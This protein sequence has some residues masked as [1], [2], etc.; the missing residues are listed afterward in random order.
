MTN[1][2]EGNYGP[3]KIRLNTDTGVLTM[4]D[5]QGV[6]FRV[7]L[8]NRLFGAILKT[9]FFWIYLRNAGKT[10]GADYAFNWILGNWQGEIQKVKETFESSKTS[11]WKLKLEGELEK[12]WIKYKEVENSA[13]EDSML[14]QTKLTADRISKMKLYA[15]QI[16][17]LE[18]VTQK[19]LKD[20][21]KQLPSDQIQWL[22]QRMHDE[23]VFAGWG[24]STLTHCNY[25]KGE[26]TVE[27]IGSFIARLYYYWDQQ[28]KT[29]DTNCSFFEGYFLGEAE[30]LFGRE[31]LQ[32]IERKCRLKGDDTCVFE[33]S[34]ERYLKKPD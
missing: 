8:I 12:S 33:I 13:E 3:A 14:V 32:C 6:L 30:L 21:L 29:G 11:G 34:L 2:V 22:W 28:G 16:D 1:I 15:Q 31:D 10:M 19:L 4:A 9:P 7:K 5:K 23:D 18:S 25:D 24:K 27:V 26:A 17:E 20:W